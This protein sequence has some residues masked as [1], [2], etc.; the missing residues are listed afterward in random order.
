MAVQG[1]Y[2]EG[3]KRKNNF[4]YT[5]KVYFKCVLTHRLTLPAPN[6]HIKENKIIN[7]NKAESIIK[8]VHSLK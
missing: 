7:K 5:Y 6:T 2:Q 1:F 4:R 8:I 3:Q